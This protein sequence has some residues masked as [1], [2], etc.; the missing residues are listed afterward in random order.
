M[1]LNLFADLFVLTRDG[2]RGALLT[3]RRLYL[4]GMSKELCFP[5]LLVIKNDDW[6]DSIYA[7]ENNPPTVMIQLHKISWFRANYDIT[8]CRSL[9]TIKG[10]WDDEVYMHFCCSL[11]ELHDLSAFIL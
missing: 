8:A 6:T 11:G 1:Y 3:I 2:I 7:D 4:N 5:A 9:M 10:K